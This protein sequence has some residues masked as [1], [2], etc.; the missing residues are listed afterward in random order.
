MAA[1]IPYCSHPTIMDSDIHEL[2]TS[3]ISSHDYLIKGLE[4]VRSLAW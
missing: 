1:L 3:L 4:C 2:I